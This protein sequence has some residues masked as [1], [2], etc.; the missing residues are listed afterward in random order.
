MAQWRIVYLGTPR[1]GPIQIPDIGPIDE[2]LITLP[3]VEYHPQ[4]ALS[5]PRHLHIIRR[6]SYQ[7][8]AAQC[9]MVHLGTPRVGPN[10]TP[11]IGPIDEGLTSTP[12]ME[13]QP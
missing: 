4:R 1:V 9:R 12:A 3:A 6:H 10:I 13:S 2:G 8:S 5:Q 11:N 7:I